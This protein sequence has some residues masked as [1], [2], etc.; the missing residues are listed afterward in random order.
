MRISHFHVE[1]FRSIKHL[2]VDLPQVCALVGPNNAGKSNVLSALRRV[3]ARDWVAASHF[4]AD[5]IYGRDPD[6]DIRIEVE[7]DPPLQYTRFKMGPAVDIGGFSFTYTRYKI[8]PRKGQPRLEQRPLNLEGEPISVPKTAPKKGQKL[9]FEALINIPADIRARVPLIYIGTN[10]SL[11]EH[12]PGARFSLLGPLFEDIDRDFNN[13]DNR[14]RVTGSDGVESEVGRAERFGAVMKEAMGLLRTDDFVALEKSIKR[15]ALRQLGFDE[16]ADADKLDFFFAPFDS[17]D[18]YKALSILVREQGFTIDAKE[19][20]EGFQNSI[21]LAILQAFEERRK[22]GAVILIEEPEMFLH[23]QMQ[24]SLYK[25]LQ[26]IGETNQV[27]YA[28]HSPHFVSVPEYEQVLLVRRGGEGTTVS[29]SALRSNDKRR[30]KLRKEL[31]P[32]RNELFFA[33]RLLL[34]EGDTEKLALP[35]YAGRLNIDL[36]RAGATIVEVGGKRNLMEF[37]K[38]ATSFGIATG[39]LYD[40]DSSDFENDRDQE[41]QYNSQLDALARTDGSVR[42][43]K[44]GKNFEHQLRT[45]LGEEAYQK[46]CQEFGGSTKPVRARLIAAQETTIPSVLTEVL[47]WAAGST[48]AT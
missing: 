43:W 12:L 41:K 34:V 2:D 27:I 7:L 40:E 13:P 10:R 16:V 28:T 19:L 29:P 5:D 39:I 3:L 48:N 36:D 33:S 18:F 24:R 38:I 46:L 37:A 9:D 20:G 45:T 14:V 4:S 23:P 17:M 1:N 31:D 32:E 6:K 22:K 30:E 11:A 42:I 21:V 35:A 47:Q 26:E 8:G 44:L 25:T 15:A